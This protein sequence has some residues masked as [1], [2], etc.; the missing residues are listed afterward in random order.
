MSGAYLALRTVI[1]IFLAAA[2]VY[3]I[4][5]QDERERSAA[6]EPEDNNNRYRA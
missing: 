5:E 2:V 1:A 6:L 3:A 4:Y